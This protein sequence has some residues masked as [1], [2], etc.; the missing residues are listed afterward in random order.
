M[1]ALMHK[2]DAVPVKELIA[3]NGGVSGVSGSDPCTAFTYHGFNG[4]ESVVV[5]RIAEWIVSR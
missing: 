2:L 1:P 4:I 3:V 5:A